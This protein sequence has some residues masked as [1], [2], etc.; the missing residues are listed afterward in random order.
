M[1]RVFKFASFKVNGL[2]GT[3][4]RKRVLTYLKKLKVDLAFI[5]ETHLTLQEHEKL[6]REGVGQIISSLSNSKT[7]GL[8]ILVNKNTPLETINITIDPSRH[9]CLC[10]F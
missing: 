1:D 9:C 6:K 5:K 4:K 10:K 3:V 2:N 7:R 8:A